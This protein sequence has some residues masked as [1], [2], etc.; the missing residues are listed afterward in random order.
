MRTTSCLHVVSIAV[1]EYVALSVLSL[2]LD[3]LWLTSVLLQRTPRTTEANFTYPQ[4][5]GLVLFRLTA[6]RT[7]TGAI[8]CDFRHSSL[9]LEDVLVAGR[10]VFRLLLV[11]RVEQLS[12]SFFLLAHLQDS[13]L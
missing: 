6:R 7:A 13:S 12:A 4:H 3:M 10:H 5:S 11:Y 9:F 1:L 2:A 8:P